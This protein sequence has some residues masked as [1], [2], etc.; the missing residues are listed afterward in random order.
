M[1][2]I[3]V[4]CVLVMLSAYFSASETAFT[5]VNRIRLKKMAED[6]SKSA[7]MA[8]RIINK[9]DKCL[10]TILVGNNIVNILTSS[11][12]TVFC[13]EQISKDN[14]AAISTVAVTLIVLIVGE[15]TPK[16]IAKNHA[17][18]ICLAT[19]RILWVLMIV[20]TPV[21]ALFL[22]I[23]KGAGKLFRNKNGTV[24]VTEQELMH[25]I[26]EIEGEG[27]LEQQESNL[28]RSALEFDE[29]TAEEILTPRVSIIGIEVNEDISAAEKLFVEEEFTRLPVY[30]KS[31]D[32][33]IGVISYKDFLKKMLEK[34]DFIV[35]DIMMET[36]YIPGLM[37]ISEVLKKMQKEK[38][39]LAV[40]VDQYGGTEGIVTLEDILEEL[41][42]EIW[43]ENDEIKAP[44]RFVSEDTFELSGELSKMDFN[45]Y[46]E[47]NDM[48][49]EIDG[50][51]NTVGGWVLELFG[52]F[53]SPGDVITAEQFEVTVK[54]VDE[55]RV[56]L[57]S[58]RILKPSETDEEE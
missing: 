35:R 2:T 33:I 9:Y 10:T 6:G 58:F 38:L 29:T 31:I 39:H 56:G 24:S 37:K 48:K 34:E 5:S 19:G 44:V 8:L 17:E 43:D 40:V 28:V 50:D 36:M 47:L 18:G 3:I 30:D 26:D 52:R 27:V 23:Q 42:G 14:G 46:F 53:P 51:F 7:K 55:R 54:T 41:V 12:A 32:H 49:Y 1:A 25:I 15:I 57:L 16:T 20:M 13:V 45:R 4:I 11:L 21:S 22:L